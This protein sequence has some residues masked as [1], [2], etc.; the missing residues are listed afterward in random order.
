MLFFQF[1]SQFILNIYDAVI[2]ILHLIIVFTAE[3]LTNVYKTG[4]NCIQYEKEKVFKVTVSSTRFNLNERA[5]S[6]F[7]MTH[8]DFETLAEKYENNNFLSGTN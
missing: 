1:G 4:E 8:D 5:S 3:S 7:T 6:V 2:I